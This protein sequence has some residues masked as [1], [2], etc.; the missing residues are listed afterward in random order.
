[1]HVTQVTFIQTDKV[2]GLQ[3]CQNGCK[4]SYL[5]NGLSPYCNSLTEMPALACSVT[6]LV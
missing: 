2:G 4:Y 5:S 3:T 6:L 1:M